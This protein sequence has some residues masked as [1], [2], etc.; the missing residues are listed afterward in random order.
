MEEEF[1]I[2]RPGMARL[3]RDFEGTK[4]FDEYMYHEQYGKFQSY[5]KSDVIALLDSFEHLGNPFL[6]DSG[7]MLDLDQSLVMPTD[8][9]NDMR[10]VKDIGLQLYTT[11][12]NNRIRSQKEA[13]TARIQKTNL[14]LFKYSL[15][16]PRQKTQCL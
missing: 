10:R 11:F 2:I 7:E 12:L 16:E 15:R 5:F 4:E 6:E 9:V 1:V 3:V 14:K 13:F 8:V